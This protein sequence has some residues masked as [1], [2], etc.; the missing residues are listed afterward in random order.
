MTGPRSPRPPSTVIERR[1]DDGRLLETV[2]VDANGALEGPFVAYDDTGQPRMRMSC[3][4]GHPDGPATLYRNGRAEVQMAFAGG[5]LANEMRRL[6]AA[7]RVI[8]I[9]RY[10]AGRRHGLM[11]CRSPE[12]RPVLTAEYRDDRL[13]GAWTE[14]H[15]DGAIRRRVHYRDDLLEGEAVDFGPDG[16][17]AQRVLY[18]AGQIVDT[19]QPPADPAPPKPKPLWRRLLGL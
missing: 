15:P 14:F 18:A 13:N 3:R 9:V 16:K 17:P 5:R 2:S 10:A 8:S 12:G 6:D 1:D 11:E 7:G 4:G 19:P